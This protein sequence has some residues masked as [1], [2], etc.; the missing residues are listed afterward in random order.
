MPF[1]PQMSANDPKR[2]L[3]TTTR[4]FD[5]VALDTGAMASFYVA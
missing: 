3:S 2:T 1:A 5:S 4:S